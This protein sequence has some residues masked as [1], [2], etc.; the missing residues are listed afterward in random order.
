LGTTDSNAKLNFCESYEPELT[1][2]RKYKV[3]DRLLVKL[4]GGRL[5]QATVKAIRETIE[6]TALVYLWQ[7][8]DG[9]D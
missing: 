8:V 3:G 4:S 5:V 6:E 9:T 7:I 1:A 2:T